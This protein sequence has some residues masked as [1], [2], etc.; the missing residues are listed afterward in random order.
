VVLSS[1][2][3]R[4]GNSCSCPIPAAACMIDAFPDHEFM[5]PIPARYSILV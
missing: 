4:A 1:Q 3:G 5:H 2:E